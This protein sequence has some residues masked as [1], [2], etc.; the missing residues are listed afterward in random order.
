MKLLVLMDEC[1]SLGRCLIVI[2]GVPTAS[3]T[4]G[5]SAVFVATALC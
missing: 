5:V 3:G 1:E 2:H 4:V